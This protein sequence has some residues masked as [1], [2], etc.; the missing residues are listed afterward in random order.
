MRSQNV[1]GGERQFSFG[2][3]MKHF[4]DNAFM[5]L[6]FPMTARFNTSFAV[7]EDKID[8]DCRPV[9]EEGHFLTASRG[10]ENNQG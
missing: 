3:K 6:L 1:C 2:Q 8:S 4:Q 7:A 10:K 9:A 5:F